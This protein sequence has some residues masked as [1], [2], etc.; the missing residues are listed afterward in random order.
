MNI[1]S[2]LESHSCDRCGGK[3]CD[4][5][6]PITGAARAVAGE[7]SEIE[8]LYEWPH[9]ELDELVLHFADELSITCTHCG[10]KQQLREKVTP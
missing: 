1:Y 9:F 6:V 4:F 2:A 3:A 8:F 5:K 10:H 7:D